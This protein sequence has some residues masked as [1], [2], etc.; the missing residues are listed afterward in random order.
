MTVPVKRFSFFKT[1][2]G[3][4][5]FLIS[6]LYIIWAAFF[7]F[8]SSF[9]GIDGQR[10]FCL[11]DDAM[12]AMRYSWNLAHGKGLVWNRG[13]RIEGY[14]NF[15][16]V[17]YIAFFCLFLSKS[18]A[19]L[20]IQI[21]GIF[22]ALFAAFQAFRIAV[23]VLQKQSAVVP[24]LVFVFALFYYPSSYW[25]IMGME[26][27]LLS[28]LL[29]SAVLRLLKNVDNK[30]DY[31]FGLLCGL[32][33]LTRPDAAISIAIMFMYKTIKERPKLN[34]PFKEALICLSFVVGLSVFRYGYYGSIVPNTYTLKM[35]GLPLGMRLQNGIA[36][37]WPFLKS[38]WLPMIFVVVGLATNFR[39]DLFF[40]SVLFLI[41]PVYQIWVGGDP[42]NYWR[43]MSPLVSL[44]FLVFLCY[45]RYYIPYLSILFR[46]YNQKISQAIILIVV[47]FYAGWKADK[48]FLSQLSL[49]D[50]P[51]QVAA[52]KDNVN[53]AIALNHICKNDSSRLCLQWAGTIAY[54]T[55]FYYIDMLGKMDKYIA[56]LPP[57]TT[58][59]ISWLGM[60]SVPGHNKYDMIYSVITC[61][62]DYVQSFTWGRANL[63]AYRDKN[64][65]KVDYMGVDLWM[66]KG[67]AS[68]QR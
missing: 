59:A 45:V 46:N 48:S 1:S 5:L 12:I 16:M 68:R 42:W 14:T 2:T 38:I 55:D 39:R 52:N 57:D 66:R 51:Y 64:F 40:L 61:R 3:Q 56:S 31:I 10:H 28:C 67:K 50:L 7:I 37:T 41:Q 20:A 53:T 43:M 65:E 60:K 63:N 34:F 11:F 33:F 26:T 25:P 18:A 17:I 21:S 8:K 35:T 22:F 15:L 27:G 9:T 62:A 23:I 30:P 36:F 13:E 58:G 19:V 44:F 4:V 24:V 6:L 54:Y 32:A 47:A 29:L 49:K